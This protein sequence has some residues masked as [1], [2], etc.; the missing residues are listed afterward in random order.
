MA[1]Q[2]GSTCYSDA[3]A[4]LSAMASAQAGAVVVHGGAAYVVD[5][6]SVTTSSIT[7]TLLP[8]AGGSPI[9]STVALTPLPCGLLDWQDGLSLGW[10]VA[11]AWV[12]T[13]AVM[14]LRKAAHQ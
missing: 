10:G 14:H 1:Y 8:V 7:Y 4:A 13:A 5:A 12:L 9:A 6:S 3:S 2:V 11:T